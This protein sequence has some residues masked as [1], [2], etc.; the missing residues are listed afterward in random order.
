LLLEKNTFRSELLQQYSQYFFVNPSKVLTPVY[1]ILCDLWNKFISIKEEVEKKKEDTGNPLMISRFTKGMK[2]LLNNKVETPKE[3]IKV[4]TAPTT[5]ITQLETFELSWFI[6]DIMSKSMYLYALGHNSD[7]T[8]ND[9]R[10][11]WSKEKMFDDDKFFTTFNLFITNFVHRI[12]DMQSAT[13]RRANNELAIFFRDLLSISFLPDFV[14][15]NFR[16]NV[17]SSLQLYATSFEISKASF[18]IKLKLDFVETL[19]DHENF[20]E[21]NS[22]LSTQNL[23]KFVIDIL[24]EG[25]KEKSNSDR[26]I[27]I[28]KRFLSSCDLNS[29][30]QTKLQKNEISGM[31]WQ[32][33]SKIIE[34]YSILKDLEFSSKKYLFIV[35]I[36]IIQNR[37]TL[38]LSKWYLNLPSESLEYFVKLLS[39]CMMITVDVIYNEKHE[40]RK[41]MKLVLIKVWAQFIS[42]INNHIFKKNDI[43]LLEQ[44]ALFVVRFLSENKKD[45]KINE[46]ILIPEFNKFL[47]IYQSI[48]CNDEYKTTIWKWCLGTYLDRITFP[49][50]KNSNNNINDI[51]GLEILLTPYESDLQKYTENKDLKIEIDKEENIIFDSDGVTIKGASLD[52]LIERLTYEKEVSLLK[53]KDIFFLTYR[54]FSN[55]FEVLDL[56]IQRFRKNEDIYNQY[57]S[58]TKQ[59]DDYMHQNLE[60]VQK[61]KS[62]T[63]SNK[64]KDDNEKIY[65]KI[66]FR[67]FAALQLWVKDFYDF[68]NLIL[69]KLILFLDKEIHIVKDFATSLKK[70][71][72]TKLTNDDSSVQVKLMFDNPPPLPIYPKSKETLNKFSTFNLLDWSEKEIAR[73]LTIIDSNLFKRILPQECL[74]GAWAKTKKYILAPNIVGLTERWNLTTSWVSSTIMSEFDPKI[75]KTYVIKFIDIAEELFEMHNF[76][77]LTAIIAG[78]QGYSINRLKKFWVLVGSEYCDKFSYFSDICSQNSSYS[79][80]RDEMTKIAPPKIPPMG[81]YL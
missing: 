42:E 66:Q 70:I 64:A 59:I 22:R 23:S 5:P 67:V 20:I 65:K 14:K 8:S 17:I 76:N 62:I 60:G 75:R 56:L 37:D 1:H 39:N 28:L 2:N 11:N 57:L 77:C 52:K 53:Y 58:E 44:C 10:F 80:M 6:F 34:D 36:H 54:S 68:S 50:H 63:E 61:D 73:Q 47:N 19:L 3:E 51:I 31:F 41:T 78:L 40:L 18:S 4:L 16:S 33:I 30:Y 32:L 29:K 72:V 35:I 48:L 26:S 13:S 74:S 43:N 27:K 49:I 25:M 46:V 79:R 81:K 45:K 69:T 71:L 9:E 7:I 38:Q 55:S 15:T 24:F 12:I 21:M